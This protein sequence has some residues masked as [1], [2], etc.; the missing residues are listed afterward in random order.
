MT[1]KPSPLQRFVQE[2]IEMNA[3]AQDMDQRE[4]G[5]QTVSLRLSPGQIRVLDHMAKQLEISR[6]AL[7][8]EFV[9]VGLREVVTEW[10]RS[11]G[12]DGEKI[13]RQISELGAYQDGDI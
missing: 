11:H 1:D 7:L 12:E 13:H 3:I 4:A 2:R 5:K 6:Q 9:T 10:A 8:V